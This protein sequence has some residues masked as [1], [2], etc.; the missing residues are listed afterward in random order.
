MNYQ[1]LRQ[2]L[3]LWNK[4]NEKKRV[5]DAIKDFQDNDDVKV[6]VDGL[7]IPL[8]AQKINQELRAQKQSLKDELD[9]LESQFDAL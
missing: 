4:I 9:E 5:L 6:R 3:D 1:T 7:E 2:G 8:K